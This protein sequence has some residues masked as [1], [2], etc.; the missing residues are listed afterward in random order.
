MAS[1]SIT[2]AELKARTEQGHLL[3]EEFYK[4]GS[5]VGHDAYVSI[6]HILSAALYGPRQTWDEAIVVSAA[7]LAETAAANS[8]KD[9]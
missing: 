6:A 2:T 9:A 8:E 4:F 5:K 3:R 1:S 7:K